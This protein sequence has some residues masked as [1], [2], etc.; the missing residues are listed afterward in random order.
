VTSDVSITATSVGTANQIISLGAITYEAV[1]HYLEFYAPRLTAAAV[2]L[3]VILRDSTTVIGRI[4]AQ[5]S[6]EGQGA[7]YIKYPITP[8]A[9]SHTYNIAAWLASAGTWTFEA[10]TGGT[11]GDG[12]ADLN[13]WMAAHRVPT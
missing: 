2:A 1:P 13:I 6:G 3:H 11:A 12:T 7:Y 4:A 9:A 8:T 10:G 5:A